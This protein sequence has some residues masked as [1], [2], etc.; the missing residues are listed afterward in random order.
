MSSLDQN[1]VLNDDQINIKRRICS[2]DEPLRTSKRLSTKRKIDYN[3]LENAEKIVVLNSENENSEDEYDDDCETINTTDTESIHSDFDDYYEENFTEYKPEKDDTTST[4]SE[5]TTSEDDD[6]N[7][8]EDYS[9]L[10]EIEDE[11]E[12]EETL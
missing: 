8:D 3:E 9:T 7:D 11:D 2:Q 5:L 10:E 4:E 1:E 12:I 6:S